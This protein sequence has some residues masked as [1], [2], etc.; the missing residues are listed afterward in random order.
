[1]CGRLATGSRPGAG[2]RAGGRAKVC[3]AATPA[4]LSPVETGLS[5]PIVVLALRS[6]RGGGSL[7]GDHWW[8]CGTWPSG[9]SPVPPGGALALL[10]LPHPPGSNSHCLW[11]ACCAPGSEHLANRISNPHRPCGV[12]FVGPQTRVHS[13]SAD[14][15][16][17]LREAKGLDAVHS[18]SEERSRDSNPDC[19]APKSVFFP[20]H[21]PLLTGAPTSCVL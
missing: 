1:M 21:P 16:V 12:V 17:R 3:G 5:D 14:E 13:L 9:R 8:R 2:G 7:R 4:P 10:P 15:G 19:V 6:I 20:W 11:E 18:D